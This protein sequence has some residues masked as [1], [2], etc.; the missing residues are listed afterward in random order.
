MV[1]LRSDSLC[2]LVEKPMVT[3]MQRPQFYCSSVQ[4]QPAVTT[5]VRAEPSRTVARRQKPSLLL[6]NSHA[7]TALLNGCRTGPIPL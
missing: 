5:V 7:R 1:L 3:V 6:P 2:S 4:L